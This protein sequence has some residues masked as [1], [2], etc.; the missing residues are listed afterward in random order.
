[1]A[2]KQDTHSC[3]YGSARGVSASYG[4]SCFPFFNL[5]LLS[6]TAIVQGIFFWVLVF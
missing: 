3:L 6:V 2:Q 4:A 1:M 5:L